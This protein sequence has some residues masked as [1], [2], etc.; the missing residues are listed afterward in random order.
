MRNPVP[1]QTVVDQ[2]LD[3]AIAQ[4]ATRSV[5]V[6]A[7][8]VTLRLL[9][10]LDERLAAGLD[11]LAVA[12]DSGRA[13]CLAALERPTC[14]ASFATAVHAIERRD[15]DLL[16]KLLAVA[17]A[18][19]QARAGLV[20]AFG[21]VS[22]QWLRGLTRPLLDS[23]NPFLRDLGLAACAMHH[24]N[25]G[26]ALDQALASTQP[27]G[28]AFTVAVK[29]GH[30]AALPACVD[31]VAKAPAQFES[32]RAALLLGDR[33][34]ALPSLHDQARGESAHRP[35]ALLLALR[36]LDAEQAGALLK[37]LSQ[38]RKSI[39]LLIRGIAAAGDPHYVPW[40]I[41]QMSELKLARLAG[42]A[43]STITG[44]DLARLDFD[45]APP[46]GEVFGPNDDPADV[47][48]ALDE[49]DGLPWPDQGKIESWWKANGA[50]F[51]PGTR[52]LVGEAPS[53]PHCLSVLKT[54]FQRQRIAAAEHLC[55][56][57]PGTPL[58]NVAAPAWRQERLLAKMTA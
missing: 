40:L 41:R 7:P 37:P 27:S 10:R 26:P 52:H 16:D 31:H 30:I 42:E 11:G 36:V 12:A 22:A 21:W 5:L 54:G 8:H 46:E 49:D 45:R 19:P 24:V 29:L 13:A 35:Q 34:T 32:A 55:L 20:S 53:I 3:D 57:Q 28:T 1:I 33:Q 44:L 50:R 43:F 39:R 48:V 15:A 17:E 23:S 58:F 2:H 51:Q 9:G 4:R 25:P 56:L 18:E 14:G 38:D 47:D 6:R